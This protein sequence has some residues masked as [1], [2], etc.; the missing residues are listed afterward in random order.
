MCKILYIDDDQTHGLYFKTI[1]NRMK[2]DCE[3]VETYEEAI[4][5]IN[6]N[7]YDIYITDLLLKGKLGTD[8]I[9]LYPDLRW[10]ILTALDEH[11]LS[12][13][14]IKLEKL[15]NIKVFHKPV[16]VNNLIETLEAEFANIAK[17]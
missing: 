1:C 16:A 4:D 6:E 13:D 14:V 8:I 7:K 9:R 2:V 10:Y 5:K 15:K 11:Q 17:T 3:V 12:G